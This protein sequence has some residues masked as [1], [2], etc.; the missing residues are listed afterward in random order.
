MDAPEP[1]S[2]VPS[3]WHSEGEEVSDVVLLDDDSASRVASSV[4]PSP[5]LVVVGDD[6]TATMKPSSSASTNESDASDDADPNGSHNQEVLEEAGSDYEP[7]YE[8][9]VAYARW[10][11]IKP[12]EDARM[13]RIAKDGLRA[14]LPPDW[15]PCRTGDGQVYYFNFTTGESDWDHPC[16]GMFRAEVE[17]ERLRA[18]EA[19]SPSSASEAVTDVPIPTPSSAS[20]AKRDGRDEDEEE[21]DEGENAS[22]GGVGVGV[23]ERLGSTRSSGSFAHAT[24]KPPSAGKSAP[25]PRVVGGSLRTTPDVVGGSL[26]TSPDVVATDAGAGVGPPR[27][28]GARRSPA[29]EASRG[30]AVETTVLLEL[31]DFS[32][33]ESFRRSGGGGESSRDSGDSG[34]DPGADSGAYSGSDSRT[35]EPEVK[36]LNLAGIG[37]GG[38]GGGMLLTAEAFGFSGTF[39][40]TLDDGEMSEASD[41][42]P[43]DGT[44]DD[45]P[46]VNGGVDEKRQR[47]QQR[48]RRRQ[49]QPGEKKTPPASP[50]GTGKPPLSPGNV[51]ESPKA[52]SM[53]AAATRAA[54]GVHAGDSDAGDDAGGAHDAAKKRTVTRPSRVSLDDENVEPNT[55]GDGAATKQARPK[56]ILPSAAD[57]ADGGVRVPAA[58]DDDPD[59]RARID[60][61]RAEFVAARSAHARVLERLSDRAEQT[62]RFVETAVETA[63]ARAARVETERADALD[64]KVGT[65][66]SS[67]AERAERAAAAAERA[68]KAV[69]RA[70]ERFFAGRA[71]SQA[72]EAL[73]AAARPTAAA[74]PAPPASASSSS[75]FR[76][77]DG[78]AGESPPTPAARREWKPAKLPP[79]PPPLPVHASTELEGTAGATRP[80]FDEARARRLIEMM[81]ESPEMENPTFVA[82]I[83]AVIDALVR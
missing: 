3:P 43:R 37:G 8:E 38:G 50:R 13:M 74:L 27:R 49:Q 22:T 82:S 25:S 57:D 55:R 52:R 30:G 33:V 81:E 60:A 10:L 32:L 41:F 2:V 26:R 79:P 35:R 78:D 54:R 53:A 42:L 47:Q 80:R 29:A 15:K 31:E 83:R 21:G 48:Q 68:E 76:S 66:L 77:L 58:R 72:S 1:M 4:E 24:P 18:A 69:D 36:P 56:S 51:V 17:A 65:T 59:L 9:T 7:T 73:P 6:G 63:M 39:D 44:K 5:R 20:V 12:H 40:S 70:L 62:D 14:K 75:S 46:N 28:K 67:M 23:E 34:A 16:D 11:G 61:L 45:E 71:A 64:A 19:P